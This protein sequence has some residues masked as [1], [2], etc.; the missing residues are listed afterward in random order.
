MNEIKPERDVVHPSQGGNAK[1]LL[2]MNITPFECNLDEKLKS[3]IQD[4]TVNYDGRYKI[5]IGL[6]VT[7]VMT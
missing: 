1:T 3:F 6:V 4:K 2:I 5:G 7:S